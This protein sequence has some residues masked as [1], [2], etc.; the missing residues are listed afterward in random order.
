MKC[1]GIDQYSI[2]V[3][4]SNGMIKFICNECILYIH[5]VD[6]A[7]R[8][9]H[10]SV[11]KNKDNLREYKYEFEA[12]LKNNE[13]EIKKL[14]EAIEI[15]YEERL[16][17]IYEAQKSCENNVKEVKQLCEIAKNFEKHSKQICDKMENNINIEKICKEIKKKL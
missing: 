5:N 9:I 11:D 16:K 15:R 17:S 12:S 14:L 8:E 4:N 1:S 2:N 7:L 3:L 10:E 13:I 6:M